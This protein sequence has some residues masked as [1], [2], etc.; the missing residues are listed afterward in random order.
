MKLAFCKLI[1]T[2]KSDKLLLEKMEN[3]VNEL[4][5]T[6]SINS[7]V[8]MIKSK[9]ELKRI[10]ELIYSPESRFHITSKSIDNYSFNEVISRNNEHDIF[11]VLQM[12][13]DRSVTGKAAV[14]LLKDY[15]KSF[16]EHEE[17]IKN[18]IDKNLKVRIGHELIK[19]SFD[20]DNIVKN[21]VIPCILGYPIE[22]HLKYF[23]E[24]LGK[25][26]KWFISRKYDGIR[27]FLIYNHT[28]EKV[29]IL[30]RSMKPITGLNLEVIRVLESNLKGMKRS[31]ILDGELVCISEDKEN[32]SKTISTVK[33]LE[34][35]PI[36][37][38]EFRVF[39]I[40][41]DNATF[42]KRQD[43]LKDLMEQL[44][45]S[46]IIKQVEQ[47]V[48]GDFDYDALIEKANSLGYEGFIIRRDCILKDG[49]SRDLLKIKPFQDA[50]LKVIDYAIGP[51]RIIDDAG[52]ERTEQVLLS[53]TIECKG[54]R[55]NV[56]SGFS[57]A[58]RKEFSKNPEL[59]LGK[60]VTVRYQSESK[61]AGRTENSLRF[62]VFKALHGTNRTE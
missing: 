20:N 36:G 54:N 39:D 61:V 30:T 57:N 48:L 43:E 28:S 58:E 56:G 1:S 51:M 22:K 11:A 33:S 60:I 4:R 31:F 42:S 16:P 10:L 41:I 32:F 44:R 29:E 2:F 23:K 38:L 9:P 37:D 35:K 49:R 47:K 12:L 6:N 17:L 21:R 52:M 13:S 18:I 53:I 3:L 19:R 62:P 46:T 26:N 45:D 15:I 7:K 59:I 50:E 34:P 24:S 14:S 5:S 40:L 8:E 25:G 27:T 55:V